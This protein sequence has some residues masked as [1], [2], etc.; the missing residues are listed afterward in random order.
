[1]WSDLPR[2]IT[3]LIPD[4]SARTVVLQLD[5]L[6]K[7]REEREA[8]IR[9]RLG[10]QQV[11]SLAGA[12]LAWQVF[13]A[14]PG[15]GG[16][17]HTVLAVAIQESVLQQYE[18]LCESVG[19]IPHEVGIT[20]LRLFNLWRKAAGR[21]SRRK[22]DFLWATVADRALTTMV[23]QQGRLLF[24][25]C[26]LLGGDTATSGR[27]TDP[28]DKVIEEC[29]ASLELCLQRHPDLAVTHAVL[30]GDGEMAALTTRAETSLGLSI[31]R[32]DWGVIDALGWVAR[33]R[34]QEYDESKRSTVFDRAIGFRHDAH[35]DFGRTPRSLSH[36]PQQP[37][38]VVVG[39]DPFRAG[40]GLC[41]SGPG[42]S[43]ELRP[44][45]FGIS[46]G[47]RHFSGARADP[48]TGHPSDCRGSARG[49]RSVRR[50]VATLA[51]RSRFGQSAD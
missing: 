28:L 14:A 51:G 31:E 29:G 21:F 8:L 17:A 50:G 48:P 26:K 43:V 33:R 27:M 41:V 39:P 13:P 44:G 12:K 38:S 10:Q 4:A 49:D 3:L 47:A 15:H 37:V 42:Y 7:D 36:Q 30:C 16:R 40:G 1:V 32:M 9:W 11:L 6:P 25:R 45:G 20:S 34:W 19:L 2:R 24:Y 46:G 22:A 18:S 23:F 35:C 5:Q